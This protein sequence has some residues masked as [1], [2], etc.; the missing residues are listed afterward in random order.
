LIAEDPKSAEIIR[1]IL[2]G[3]DVK[4]YK[5]EFADLW[6]IYVPWHFPLHEDFSIK[7]ASK[8]AEDAFQAEYSAV[9]KH[10]SKYKIQLSAR[11]KMETGIRYEWYALQRWGSNYWKEFEKEKIVWLCISDKSVFAIDK[12]KMF[13]NNAVYFFHG[14][15]LEAMCCLL[16]SKV[17]EWYFDKI[18]TATGQGTN[19]WEKFVVELIPLPEIKENINTIF[20]QLVDKIL[21]KKEK[22]ESTILEEKEID[23]LVHKLYG[24]TKEEI[25]II[26]NKI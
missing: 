23:N 17:I 16:N 14:K 26:E 10:L 9:Y 22:G 20:K 24:F 13:A 3:R 12:E 5:A 25:Q 2:R 1:P 7:G 21:I 18:S 8:K 15:N 4:K 19:K 11:N 6:L